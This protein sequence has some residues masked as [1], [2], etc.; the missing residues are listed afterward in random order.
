MGGSSGGGTQ[1]VVQDMPE[2]SKP[3]WRGIASAGR[4][5]AR[6]PYEAYPGDRIAPFDPFERQAFRGVQQ[7]YN[8][9]PRRELGQA[10]GIAGQVSNVG[11]S[12]PKFYNQ[13]Q[14]YMNPYLENVLD[15]GRDRMMRDYQSA[16]G[17]SRRNTSDAAIRS[18]TVGGRGLLSQARESAAISDEAFRAMREFEAD[19]RFQAFDRA[20]QAFAGDVQSEQAGARLSLDAA[21]QLEN[22]A[23]TQQAQQLQR[24][25]AMQEAGV[26]KRQM[27]QAI[28]DQ[29][30]ADFLERK[31]YQRDQI[32]WLASLLGPTPYGAAMNTAT[33]ETRSG[34]GATQA[35]TGL[36]I[37]GLGAAGKYFE[38]RGN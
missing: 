11:L 16:L 30:L 24:I 10:E 19:T 1:T 20:Q 32:S 26:S 38:S 36:G 21:S 6:Q 3:Y 34:P 4:R 14:Q 23:K 8:Q 7:I 2:W 22:L 29:A 18:G 9:G 5:I 27:E 17:D 25:A 33:T 12:T 28:R 15:L 35:I 37:A 31:N 13:Y